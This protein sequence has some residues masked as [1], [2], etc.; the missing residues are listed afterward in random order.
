MRLYKELIDRT[1]VMY[2]IQNVVIGRSKPKT[3]YKWRN[4]IEPLQEEHFS[5]ED[6]SSSYSD[7][8]QY[9]DSDG[10]KWY[11]TKYS[12][13]NGEGIQFLPA[14]IKGLTSK[15]NLLLAEYDAG[16]RSSTRNEIVAILDELLRRKE[17]SQKE[18]KHINSY[19]AKCL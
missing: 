18:Y 10:E 17:I 13:K 7:G 11:D 16:N 5:S 4:I 12:L 15:L 1:N 8:D 3:T 6:E 19:L 2:N 9:T 14:D